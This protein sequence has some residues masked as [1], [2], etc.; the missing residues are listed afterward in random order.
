[1]ALAVLQYRPVSTLPPTVLYTS[2]AAMSL[3]THVLN[4]WCSMVAGGGACCLLDGLVGGGGSAA[5][6]AAADCD[7]TPGKVGLG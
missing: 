7:L 1:V 5:A 2:F 4:I 6:A 3:A